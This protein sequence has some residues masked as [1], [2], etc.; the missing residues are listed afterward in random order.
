MALPIQFGIFTGLFL[1]FSP[2]ILLNSLLATWTMTALNLLGVTVLIALF[3]RHQ[4]FCRYICPT[5]ALCDAASGIGIKQ[6]KLN[7]IPLIHK[8]LCI[9]ALVLAALGAP[10]LIVIDPVN[11]FY[12]FFDVFQPMPISIILLKSSGFI[13]LILINICIP[14]IWCQR[15]CPLG[16]LQDIA[17]DIKRVVRE[18]SASNKPF[19]NQGRRYFFTGVLSAGLSLILQ[20]YVNA[21]R[22]VN[23]RP[24]G[25]VDDSNFKTLCA[26]CGNCV[27]VCPSNII[28]SYLDAH[29]LIGALTPQIQ[30][31][32]TYCLPECILC[33]SVCPS[34][35]IAKFSVEEKRRLV[36]GVARI[37]LAGCLLTNNKECDRCKTFC[38]YGAVEI[39]ETPD[40]FSYYPFVINDLCVGCGACKIVCPVE[41][42]KIEPGSSTSS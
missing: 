4:F 25:A 21:K 40:G 5:G 19:M 35:A 2:Y 37:E 31:K 34:G 3:F 29:D 36:I 27:K 24:P 13:L 9:M 8:Y 39:K 23:L 11:I 6:N 33:G 32:Q 26:R 20:K 18:R 1:W 38:E 16:G 10:M 15:L 22:T 28:K 14:H 41:V 30:F 42:I 17:T 7:R 12:A